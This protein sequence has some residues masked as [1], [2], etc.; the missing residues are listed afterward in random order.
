MIVSVNIDM[1]FVVTKLVMQVV[2]TTSRN[3]FYFH[4]EAYIV[5]QDLSISIDET[6]HKIPCFK[7]FLFPL[8]QFKMQS[9]I[10][11]NYN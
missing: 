9:I 10:F 11:K 5:F 4:G 6:H 7:M 8:K 2:K 3:N 1:T